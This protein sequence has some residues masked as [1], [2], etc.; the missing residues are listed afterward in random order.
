MRLTIFVIS[1]LSVSGPAAA[2]EW[3]EYVNTQDGFKVHFPG[4]PTVTEITWES[5]LDYTLPGRVY[6]ANRGTEH[7]SVTVVDYTGLEQQGIERSK[8][9]PPGT[10][11]AVKC[12]SR[13]R[14]GLLEAR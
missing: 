2:Q 5:Q 1:V 13:P 8:T 10:R 4:Q 14:S 12:W 3:E 9:C 7:Y 6:S 11:S